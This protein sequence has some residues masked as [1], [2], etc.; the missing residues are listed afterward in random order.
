MQS[1][2][3]LSGRLKAIKTDKN[4]MIS[5]YGVI[6]DRVVTIVFFKFL[7]DAFQNITDIGH[8]KYHSCGTG[9]TAASEDDYG[10]EF[11]IGTR[12]SGTQDE[13]SEICYKSVATIHFY[14]TFQITEHGIFNSSMGGELLDRSTFVPIPVESGD[15]LEFTF[16]LCMNG[17]QPSS[18]LSS[19][20]RSS[21]SSSIGSSSSSSS[22]IGSS[23][24]SSIGSSSSSSW[25]GAPCPVPELVN[26]IQ[27]LN[28][29]L[30]CLG[31]TLYGHGL[32]ITKQR[33]GLQS[34]QKS[35]SEIHGSETEDSN[36]VSNITNW[37]FGK[38]PPPGHK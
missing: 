24:S 17:E 4:E 8:F 34:Y 29:Y 33:A 30:K 18:S 22:S 38:Y 15:V 21:S 13:E 19:S 35:M 31:A 23:S 14:D 32:H 3:N 2:L 7:T 12:S 11:P 25:S 26:K 28:Q 6:S 37:Y 9:T 27:Q 36:E 1:G 20:S 10:L 5:D 16:I